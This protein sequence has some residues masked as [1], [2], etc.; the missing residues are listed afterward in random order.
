MG[1]A[2]CTEME[3]GKIRERLPNQRPVQDP[4]S[5]DPDLLKELRQPAAAGVAVADAARREAAEELAQKAAAK[6]Q[7]SYRGVKTRE[8]VSLMREN[9]VMQS[10]EDPEVLD[11][12][13][14]NMMLQ[15][16]PCRMADKP[17]AISPRTLASFS[18][19]PM[20]CR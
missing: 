4:E 15:S 1:T 5:K 2:C 14:T 20:W 3:N 7:A 12:D 11:V 19:K 18:S 17:E 6:I 9:T 13:I 16:K 10:G 8:T